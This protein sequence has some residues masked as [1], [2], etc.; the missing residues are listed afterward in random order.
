MAQLGGHQLAPLSLSQVPAKNELS[1]ALVLEPAHVTLQ[2]I[3]SAAVFAD[4]DQD[5]EFTIALGEE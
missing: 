5:V 2:A 3:G 4:A 1:E